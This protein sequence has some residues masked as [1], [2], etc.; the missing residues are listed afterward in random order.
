VSVDKDLPAPVS[1]VNPHP[2]GFDMDERALELWSKTRC[3]RSA[4]GVFAE[5]RSSHVDS[6]NVAR[7]GERRTK[8]H[9]TVT[10]AYLELWADEGGRV[11]VFDKRTGAEFATD[12]VN[13]AVITGFN[14]VDLP[15]VAPDAIE[16]ALGPGEGAAVDAIVKLHAGA[17]PDANERAAIARFVALHFARTPAAR[18][19]NDEL[20][21]SLTAW[22]REM[23]EA[24]AKGGMV[25]P[26]TVDAAPRYA[27]DQND[28]VASMLDVIESAWRPLYFRSWTVVELADMVTSDFPVY[29]QAKPEFARFGLG[30]GTAEE[31]AFALGPGHALVLSK[32]Y[33]GPDRRVT[34]EAEA[35]TYLRQRI[36]RSAD[37]FTFR[38]PGAPIPEGID[39]RERAV[40]GLRPKGDAR[41]GRDTSAS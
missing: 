8:R 27:F 32:P 25:P 5:R 30:I 40:W 12:P 26:E 17:F 37:R 15:G 20:A 4:V 23:T 2:C 28:Q 11:A 10:R 34:L 41:G 29:L 18:R 33:M 39:P 24:A 31:I 22:V 13:A 35:E 19:F 16:Q 3:Q 21:S 9:H 14:A 38:R 1:A 6:E 36:W 7:S